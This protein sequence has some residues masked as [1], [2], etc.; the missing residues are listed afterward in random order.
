VDVRGRDQLVTGRRWSPHALAE[1][2]HAVIIIIVVFTM[3]NV[4]LDADFRIDNAGGTTRDS[5]NYYCQR[6]LLFARRREG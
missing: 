5:C 4:G 2:H 3:T 6:V 1:H